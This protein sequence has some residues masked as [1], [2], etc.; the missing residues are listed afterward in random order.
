MFQGSD[1]LTIPLLDSR[2]RQQRSI[3]GCP[4]CFLLTIDCNLRS[5]AFILRRNKALHK[6]S[7]AR[8]S[9]LVRTSFDV[10]AA[11]G[12]GA[13]AGTA[14]GAG[15]SA[16]PGEG[17]GLGAGV[18]GL[19][20]GAGWGWGA[21]APALARRGGGAALEKAVRKTAAA[22]SFPSFKH[23]QRGQTSQPP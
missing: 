12:A 4:R 11:S 17:A 18:G 20:A 23:Q 8:V 3:C 10:A 13:A 19:G 16:G 22:S 6:C 15:A 2:A 14:A 7:R 1:A 21:G 5:F 9:S